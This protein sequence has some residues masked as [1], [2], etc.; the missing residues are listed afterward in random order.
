[1]PQYIPDC[2]GYAEKDSE[3][4]SATFYKNDIINKGKSSRGC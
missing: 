2:N 3:M 4:K 1:M